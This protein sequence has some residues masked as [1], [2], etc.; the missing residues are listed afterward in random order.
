[1]K[2]GMRR[3]PRS[4]LGGRSGHGR[5]PALLAL[6]ATTLSGCSPAL[7]DTVD[8]RRAANDA[9][10][11]DALAARLAGESVTALPAG[12]AALSEAGQLIYVDATGAV[13]F[14]VASPAHDL[15]V[16]GEGVCELGDDEL[17]VR[18]WPSGRPLGAL[19]R[20]EGGQFVGGSL[21][22][23]EF[24]WVEALGPRSGRIGLATL[25]GGAPR[26][27][28]RLPADGQLGA[29]LLRAGVLLVPHDRH[30][31]LFLDGESGQELARRRSNDDTIDWARLDGRG[32]YYGGRRVYALRPGM[33]EQRREDAVL[34][35][36]LVLVPAPSF[37][38]ALDP[39]PRYEGRRAGVAQPEPV[40]VTRVPLEP[41][42]APATD[43]VY[44]VTRGYVFAFDGTGALRF[45]HT[46]RSAP[47]ASL[48]TA[49]GLT[50]VHRDGAL[51][52]L[53]PDDGSLRFERRLAP[54]R[55]AR[56][57][58]GLGESA[59]A[60]PVRA[61]PDTVES[62]LQVLR[63]RDTSQ[64]PDQVY[65]AHL[66]MTA[67]TSVAA[68]LLDVYV[69]PTTEPPV[70]DAVAM[71][72]RAR[73]ADTDPLVAALDQRYDFLAPG[74]ERA[75]PPLRAILPALARAGRTDAYDA[76]LPH[77]D[78]P[79]T[80][81]D[82]LPALIDQLVRWGGPAS[83]SPLLSFVQ[84]YRA[85]STFA[86]DPTA[87]L[88]A[89]LAVE[90]L[91]DTAQRG[92]LETWL[93]LPG[94]QPSLLAAVQQARQ[95]GARSHS[96]SASAGQGEDA[97]PQ[98]DT[99][100]PP[101]TRLAS[102]DSVEAHALAQLEQLTPCLRA[103]QRGQ[104][105]LRTVR[106]RLVLEREGRV[107]LVSVLPGDELERCI[108]DAVYAMRWPHIRVRRQQVG[109]TLHLAP[110]QAP[111]ASA[112]GVLWWQVA[113][114][115]APRGVAAQAGLAWWDS[116][117]GGHTAST[118]QDG[119]WRPVGETDAADAARDPLDRWWRPPAEAP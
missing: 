1:M 53:H 51:Q 111:E 42:A 14:E 72:L 108:A 56:A 107:A 47:L 89:A 35:A 44:V 37:D 12:F 26:V 84:R 97:A 103:A 13:P 105:S 54:L 34:D 77:L 110:D 78:L 83:L 24:A 73:S 113:A 31:L 4:A 82:V 49:D 106:V 10:P 93:S 5:L 99:T 8:P 62:L 96:P 98:V 102:A 85:D 81:V 7:P 29:P 94:T 45:V 95:E 15:A 74:G 61:A 86:E 66:L 20:V 25:T 39:T 75:P 71:T 70:R 28:H 68:S 63:A 91:G 43:R 30:E 90:R 41:S 17:S 109:F 50:L 87:L 22:G 40:H 36:D 6:L 67:P 118:A 60:V 76:L 79:E 57:V 101:I 100:H 80:P 117:E 65:A 16:C 32:T 64:L 46:L 27:R 55:V 59:R 21:E 2:R 92:Q 69:D 115:R 88:H 114:A 119:W 48:A 11:L 116:P 52:A 104:P 23:A 58:R 3:T 9:A 18:A 38:A 33:A 112:S 19:A